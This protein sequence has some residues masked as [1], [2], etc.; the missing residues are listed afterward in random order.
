MQGV[1]WNMTKVEVGILLLSLYFILV[2]GHEGDGCRSNTKTMHIHNYSLL[3]RWLPIAIEVD[4]YLPLSLLVWASVSP[5]PASLFSDGTHLNSNDWWPK[6]TKKL[7]WCL[8]SLLYTSYS[9]KTDAIS[10]QFVCK[11]FFPC[12]FQ[13]TLRGIASIWKNSSRHV[14]NGQWCLMRPDSQPATVTDGLL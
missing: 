1:V 12:P 13:S 8:A 14:W 10:L 3:I 6:I 2:G 11:V 9:L 5:Y 4:L 7:R